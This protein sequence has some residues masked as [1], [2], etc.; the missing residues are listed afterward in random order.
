VIDASDLG[1]DLVR[2]GTTVHVIDGDGKKRKY[3]IVGSAEAKPS[4]MKL[5]NESPAGKAL[6]GHKKGEQVA[7]S[8]P[9]GERRLK[10]TKIE[11][12]T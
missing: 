9:K 4:E 11:V 6:I 8:T 7:F 2:I 12:S 5:S 10:I 3:T 1:N